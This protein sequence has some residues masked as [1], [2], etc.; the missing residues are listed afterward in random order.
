MKRKRK[1][2]ISGRI[3]GDP[4]Y[5]EK[6]WQVERK[7]REGYEVVNPCHLYLFGLPMVCYSWR[8][9]MIVTVWNLIK[10]PMVFMLKDWKESRGARIEH[11]IAKLLFKKIYYQL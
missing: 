3:T 5:V 10:C 7:L 2:F 9:C 4:N 11:R 8:T 6:F 1:I